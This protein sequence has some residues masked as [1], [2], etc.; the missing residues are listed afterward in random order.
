M[1]NDVKIIPRT[2]YHAMPMPTTAYHIT[3][4]IANTQIFLPSPLI[5]L[6]F[7]LARGTI[8]LA[9]AFV[10]FPFTRAT[11][12]PHTVSVRECSE[13]SRNCGN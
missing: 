1:T 13:R 7:P 12:A 9:L 11:Q 10:P 6:A 2:P 5:P 3:V 4:I 8:W